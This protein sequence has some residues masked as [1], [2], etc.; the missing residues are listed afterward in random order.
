M[1]E[2]LGKIRIY[3]TFFDTFIVILPKTGYNKT[4]SVIG[5]EKV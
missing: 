4:Q 1:Y 3:L 5:D 2:M